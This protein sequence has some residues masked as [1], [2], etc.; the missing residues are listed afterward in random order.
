[1]TVQG[2]SCLSAHCTRSE[3]HMS[4][5][6]SQ[7][8]LQKVLENYEKTCSIVFAK[9]SQSQMRFIQSFVNFQQLLLTWCQS[10]TSKQ[11]SWLQEYYSD[12]SK[13][14]P[15]Y[16]YSLAHSVGL[17]NSVV[18]F[19]IGMLAAAYD[20]SVVYLDASKKIVDST[21]GLFN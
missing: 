3:S 1:M 5:S 9:A 16:Y 14:V 18:R 13:Q 2:Y 6:S 8:D 11:I 19:N 17:I 7:K 20:T 10:L 4:P 21:F 12:V 15:S